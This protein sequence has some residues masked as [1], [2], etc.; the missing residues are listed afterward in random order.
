MNEKEF[1]SELRK[2]V[3]ELLAK[4]IKQINAEALQK[5][6]LQAES[7]PT[8]SQK[9]PDHFALE[10]YKAQISSNLEVTKAV[11]VFAGATL[12][13]AILINGGAAV[14]VLSFLS[15]IIKENPH[16]S[17]IGMLASSMACF[18]LGVLFSAV[19]A[20]L[21]Y[22]TQYFYAYHN[23][24]IGKKYHRI[25]AIVIIASYLAFL[26]GSFFSYIAIKYP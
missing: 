2:Q 18:V 16:N 14:A 12:K 9:N 3:D 7:A 13:S 5:L 4:G 1:I 23:D 10:Q 26:F 21:A 20:G 6:L 19:S 22:L 15:G 24:V 17:I 11:F 8:N 25:T